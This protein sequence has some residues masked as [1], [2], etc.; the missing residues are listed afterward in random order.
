MG[1]TFSMGCVYVLLI[2]YLFDLVD[3]A[4]GLMFRMISCSF[5][6]PHTLGEK[7]YILVVVLTR[8]LMSKR[9]YCLPLTHIF[10]D[11][12]MITGEN[13]HRN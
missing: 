5:D 13:N 1:S 12:R 3:K 7:S 10:R 9:Y 6:S 11:D 4:D 2:T 8:S